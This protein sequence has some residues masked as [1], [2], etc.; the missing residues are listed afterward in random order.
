MGGRTGFRPAPSRARTLSRCYQ[1]NGTQWSL[2]RI[3][4]SLQSRIHGTP[5]RLQ[6]RFAPQSSP[7]STSPQA[8]EDTARS[9]PVH[10]WAEMTD[11]LDDR[12]TEI[13]AP[14]HT[15]STARCG[16]TL[17]SSKPAVPPNAG[18]SLD[19]AASFRLACACA[20]DDY[21]TDASAWRSNRRS[22]VHLTKSLR[23]PVVG[24]R[25]LLVL[26]DFPWTS[27]CTTDAEIPL[28]TDFNHLG[29]ASCRTRCTTASTKS[30][31]GRHR[32]RRA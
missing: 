28:V 3:L 29:T 7:A 10:K 15:I 27:A 1:A 18:G 25:R 20:Q 23:D 31:V 2:P 13:S 4:K 11:S 22:I 19:P 14:E 24:K 21:Y 17:E 16:Q 30:S 32:R 9:V 26:L 12:A 8:P 6:L 5:T